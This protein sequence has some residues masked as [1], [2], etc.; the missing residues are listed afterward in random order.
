MSIVAHDLK[1]PLNR[2]KGVAMLMEAER[3]LTEDQKMHVKLMTDAT[4]S[5]GWI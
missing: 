4:Q 2:I 5:R 1:S 3:G